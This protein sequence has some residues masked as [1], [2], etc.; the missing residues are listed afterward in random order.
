[1]AAG[2]IRYAV[3]MDVAIMGAGYVGLVTA[4]CLAHLGHDVTCVDVDPARV[5]RLERGD[6]P[7]REPGLDELVTEGLSRGR[8]RFSADAA[9]IRGCQLVIVCVGTLDADDEWSDTVVSQAVATITPTPIAPNQPQKRTRCRQPQTSAA[10]SQTAPNS[11]PPRWPQPVITSR[12]RAEPPST[13]HQ[14]E[15]A[16]RSGDSS[17]DSADC[18]V[19]ANTSPDSSARRLPCAASTS[20]RLEQP[21]ARIIMLV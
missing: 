21:R 6:L 17:P 15:I 9:A 7:I 8:L 10:A 12:S 19:T 1:M 14:P 5:G 3:A 4:A 13:V 16:S 11:R 2:A 20:S 18:A